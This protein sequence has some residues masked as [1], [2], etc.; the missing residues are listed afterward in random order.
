MR[1]AIPIALLCALAA[2]GEAEMTPEEQEAADAEA[3]A[4][5][6]ASQV[7]PVQPINPRPITFEDIESE[8]LSGAGC[9]FKT[10]PQA[11]PIALTQPRRGYMKLES[12]IQRFA[13]DSGSAKLPLD[14]HRKYTGEEY[15]FELIMDAGGGTQS[16][17]ETVD[18]P[19]S[20][21][22]VRDG[23]ARV[24]YQADGLVQCGS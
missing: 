15:E 2:C 23:K 1:F 5:V 18:Y 7:P 22:T 19:G 20:R 14:T 6:Q 10:G 24:V 13:A 12:E 4:Q 11:D 9:A 17:M 21:L 16:G 3:I 8:N